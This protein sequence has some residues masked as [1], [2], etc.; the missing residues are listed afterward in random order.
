MAKEQREAIKKALVAHLFQVFIGNSWKPTTGTRLS[1]EELNTQKKKKNPESTL[2]TPNSI[3][4]ECTTL[5]PPPLP[6][7]DE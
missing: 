7:P 1:T 5:L 4:S 3:T 6:R 2:K